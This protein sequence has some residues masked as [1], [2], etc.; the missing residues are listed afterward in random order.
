MEDQPQIN[1]TIKGVLKS[2]PLVLFGILT[3][4]QDTYTHNSFSGD[5]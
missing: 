5:G 3:M 2:L 4:G 1:E